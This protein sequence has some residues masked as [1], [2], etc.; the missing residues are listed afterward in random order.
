MIFSHTIQADIFDSVKYLHGDYSIIE[1]VVGQN[2]KFYNIKYYNS[3][4]SL[5]SYKDIFTE[6][7]F[8][9]SNLAQRGIPANKIV[10]GKPSMYNATGFVRP[11]RL[12]H[13]YRRANAQ[14][15]WWGGAMFTPYISRESED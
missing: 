11:N 10:I 2:I 9:V 3:N 13:F 4:S 8:S 7:L 1:K 5:S 15:N 12:I 6:G 14:L